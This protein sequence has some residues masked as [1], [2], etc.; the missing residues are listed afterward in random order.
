MNSLILLGAG[1]IFVLTAYI[2]YG[3][4]LAKQLGIDDKN[5]TPAHTMNDGID[6]VPTKPLILFGHHFSAI[7]GAGPIVG[8]VLGAAFGWLPV[9]LWLVVGGIFIGAVHDFTSLVASIRHSGRS[10]GEVVEAR[11]GRAGKILFLLFSW[12]ALVIICAAFT[13]IDAQTFAEHPEA[14]SSSMMFMIIAMLFGFGVYRRNFSV[15]LSSVIGVALLILC[16][17]LGNIFPIVL[18][19][20]EW[21]WILLVYIS[22]ASVLP[23]WLLLQPRDYLNAYLLFFMIIGGF[24]GIIIGHPTIQ[25]ERFTGFEQNIGYLFPILF[26]TVA[27]GAIS[28]FHSLVSSGTSSKQLGR[29]SDARIIGYGAMVVE[30]LVGIMALIT[31]GLLTK[32]E[33]LN[34]LSPDGGG[35]ILLFS[36]GMGRIM[37]SFGLPYELGVNFTALT[38]SAF[39]LT[40]LDAAAR[41]TRYNF[42]EF[43]VISGKKEQHI[44][45]TNRYIATIISVTVAGVLA[46][47]GSYLVL[48]PLFGTSNQLLATLALLA[49]SVW[50]AEIQKRNWFVKYPMIF[51]FLVTISAL[52]TVIYQNFQKGNVVQVCFGVFLLIVAIVLVFLAVKK[53][54]KLYIAAKVAPKPAKVMLKS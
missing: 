45:A 53:M 24:V 30:T 50:L 26:V 41:I 3:K 54:M 47:S 2:V 44:L 12:T 17:W 34:Y 8:P 5:P 29:E 31:A 14:G 39:V 4:Y 51:M 27:C 21:I 49:V 11:V 38:V 25:M 36:N 28:G 33:Y 20:T 19:K 13:N 32:G 16:I 23:V 1:F 42:Q 15:G 9:Y 6:Y 46:L 18:S 10:I 22:I 48:W 43:F 7:A 37:E 52:V 35:P 40:T